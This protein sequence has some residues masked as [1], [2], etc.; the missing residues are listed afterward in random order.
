VSRHVALLLAEGYVE[1]QADPHD[2]RASILVLTGKGHDRVAQM[3]AER[4][5]AIARL[6][7]E[8][9]PRDRETLARLLARFNDRFE[10]TAL[11]A[12]PSQEIA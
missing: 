1:R 5:A 2:G 6:L 8:W 11:G 12:D 10:T 4:D 9:S 3:R 7:A